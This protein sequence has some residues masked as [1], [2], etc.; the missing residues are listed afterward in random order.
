[1]TV[2][3]DCCLKLYLPRFVQRYA[4]QKTVTLLYCIS[5]VVLDSYYIH[6][7]ER[8]MLLLWNLMVTV[9]LLL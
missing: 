9:R 1:M 6:E 7:D 4:T 2:V 8:T 3:R 5:L